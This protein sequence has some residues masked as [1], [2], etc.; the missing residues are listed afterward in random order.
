MPY[1]WSIMNVIDP[2]VDAA[3]GAG[4]MEY[5][6]LVT[7]AGDSVFARPG[8]HLP[9]YVTVHEVGHNWFQG[10]L[11]S[12]EVEEAWLDEGVDE[13][14]DAHVMADLYGARTSA[15]DW[16]DFQAEVGTWLAAPS[17]SSLCLESGH[18]PRR[19]FSI[20][21]GGEPLE[22]P[23]PDRSQITGVHQQFAFAIHRRFWVDQQ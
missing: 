3:M 19:H 18:N 23:L 12:N 16:M 17:E 11:A 7:T 21:A 4:G 1:P 14:A 2:P 22:C 5:P 20:H 10:M 8:I 13:W 9:E 6:T 15:V